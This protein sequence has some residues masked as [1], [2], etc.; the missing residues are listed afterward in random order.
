M[1]SLA[2]SKKVSWALTS[3]NMKGLYAQSSKRSVPSP[4]N[5]LFKI[6]F[7]FGWVEERLRGQTKRKRTLGGKEERNIRGKVCQGT[8]G[9]KYASV[10]NSVKLNHECPG[11]SN[12]NRKYFSWYVDYWFRGINLPF[13]R[14]SNMFDGKYV[15]WKLCLMEIMFDRKYVWSKICLME[16]M[17]DS[18][19]ASNGLIVWRHFQSNRPV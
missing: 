1:N 4:N 3:H 15:W 10:C 9:A 17:F 7:L 2:S 12:V 14:R 6:Q 11:A 18:K 19:F 8:L 16:I 13:I 5:F